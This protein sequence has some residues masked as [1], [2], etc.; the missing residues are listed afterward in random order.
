MLEKH[1]TVG[2][3]AWNQGQ[4]PIRSQGMINDW[5]IVSSGCL[6]NVE[7]INRCHGFDNQLF[8]DHVDTDM[9]IKIRNIGY[10]TVTTNKV[11]LIHY[12]GEKTDKKTVRGK[13]Y[14]SHSP[15]RVYYMVRNGVVLFKR[16]FFKRPLWV[17]ALIKFNIREGIY[18]LC[19]QKNKLKNFKLLLVAWFDGIFNRLGK[20]RE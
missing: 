3:V 1:G 16:Y 5:F 13:P 19:F 12:L 4:R 18:L 10:K 14:F 8:I 7:A 9:N 17:M 11:Q 20:Y 6:H 2:L 15:V